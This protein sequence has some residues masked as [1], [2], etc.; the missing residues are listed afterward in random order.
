[1]RYTP[2]PTDT[3]DQLAELAYACG[4]DLAP[5][6]PRS[7]WIDGIDDHEL[8]AELTEAYHAGQ[9]ERYESEDW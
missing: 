3:L 5:E 8:R 6:D 7:R 1:M 9:A 4:R 2:K